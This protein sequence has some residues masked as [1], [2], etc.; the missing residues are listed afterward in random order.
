MAPS[1]KTS[2]LGAR[3]S[4]PKHR[5]TLPQLEPSL[6][7]PRRTIFQP[8]RVSIKD[9]PNYN[10]ESQDQ[11]Q[12]ESPERTPS[13]AEPVPDTSEM[14]RL[15]LEKESQQY[16]AG[17]PGLDKK[18]ECATKE[19]AANQTRK[20]N[21]STVIQ[22]ASSMQEAWRAATISTP[23]APTPS[24]LTGTPV[25]P[26]PSSLT[27]PKTE[28]T[29]DELFKMSDS[30]FDMWVAGKSEGWVVE[31]QPIDFGTSQSFPSGQY[32]GE[33]PI[34]DVWNGESFFPPVEEV[35]PPEIWG[36]TNPSPD[37]DLEAAR[38]GYITLNNKE[39]PITEESL[40]ELEIFG[41]DVARLRSAMLQ[42]HA[43]NS[44]RP[45]PNSNKQA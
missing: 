10:K 28:P 18:G 30:D 5:R 35:F 37:A 17:R 22:P 26:T 3:R 16:E 25:P 1:R 27:P 6:P 42:V 12:F 9:L 38:L 41:F 4:L 7:Q 34:P 44:R 13:P 2:R 43:E 24:P 19:L 21:T 39:Y 23:P 31:E 15:V 36:T 14:T 11:E 33:A 32:F 40:S 29:R 20:K 45:R 8:R